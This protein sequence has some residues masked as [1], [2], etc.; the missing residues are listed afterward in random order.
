MS[1][2]NGAILQIISSL[3]RIKRQVKLFFN[4]FS[5]NLFRVNFDSFK[6]KNI[7]LGEF[8]KM[9]EPFLS[10]GEILQVVHILR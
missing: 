8:I 7:N 9:L 5:L 2:R 6:M 10:F 4:H 3:V 1:R